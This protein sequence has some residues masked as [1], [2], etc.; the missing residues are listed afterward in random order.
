MA[1]SNLFIIGAAKAGT[2]SLHFYL[3]QH[4]QVQMSVTKEPHFFAGTSTGIPYPMGRVSEL[5]DYER[6]FDPAFEVRGEASPSY[7]AHPRRQGVPKRIKEMIPNARFIYLVRDPISRTVSHYHHAVAAG[8]EKRSLAQ[9]LSDEARDTYSYL[10]CQSFYARQL[11][12]YLRHFP[13]YQLMVIDH[14]ELLNKRLET[15]K[16][17]FGFLGVDDSFRSPQFNREL[18]KSGERYVATPTYTKLLKQVTGR[19]TAR[20][21]EKFRRPIRRSIER[22]FLAPLPPVSLDNESQHRLADLYVNDVEE[23]RRLTGQ[24]FSSW[25]I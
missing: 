25:Q 19:R 2:T 6:L 24:R 3:D 5:Q 13:E 23:L 1:L 21:P 18:L 12:H 11:R 17:V 22:R 20:I 9:A 4:P 15:L 8:I 14:Q 16:D 7:S 10:T